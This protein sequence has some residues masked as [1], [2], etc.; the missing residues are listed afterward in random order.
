MGKLVG[1][2]P[3]IPGKPIFKNGKM[4]SNAVYGL[5]YFSSNELAFLSMLR[6]SIGLYG[7]LMFNIYDPQFEVVRNG[8]Q[9]NPAYIIYAQFTPLSFFLHIASFIQKKNGK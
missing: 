4:T 1:N 8:G 7:V 5:K 2:R 6:L 3:D 9:F